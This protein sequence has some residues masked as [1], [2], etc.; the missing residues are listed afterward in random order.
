MLLEEIH[1][2]L[3]ENTLFEGLSEEDGK[4]LAAHAKV[5]SLKP[6][7]VLFRKSESATHF[8]LVIKGRI[9]LS[10][11]SAEGSEKVV[12]IV[13]SGMTFAEAII[14]NGLSGYPLNATALS[15]SKVLC[16]N[17][18]E[19]LNIL[20]RSPEACIKVMACLSIRLHKLMSEIDRLS[21]HNA[22]YRLVSYLLESVDPEQAGVVEVELSVPKHVI[23]SRISVTPETLSRTLKKLCKDGLLEAHEQHVTLLDLEKLRGFMVNGRS[24]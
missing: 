24:C 16:I 12:D 7:E 13:S 2:I 20:N 1:S 11:L 22:T 4:T 8:F 14:L 23:A 10:L 15:S 5:C 9:K 19:F 18:E 21:L 6:S 17:A 3:R